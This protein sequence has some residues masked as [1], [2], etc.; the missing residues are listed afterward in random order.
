MG[1]SVFQGNCLQKYV[2]CSI[3]HNLPTFGLEGRAL[4]FHLNFE[5]KNQ[6]WQS[7]LQREETKL[8][9]G[10]LVKQLNSVS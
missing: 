10:T 5:G 6:D 3:G 4:I 1:V 8:R 7:D 9:N 2:A